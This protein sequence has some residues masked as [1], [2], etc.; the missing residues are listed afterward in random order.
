M[1][2]RKDMTKLLALLAL[3]AA[4]PAA[5][6][7]SSD[8]VRLFESACLDGQAQLPAGEALKVGFN[9]LPAV[10]QQRLNS[11]ASANVWRISGDRQA[12]LYLLEYSASGDAAR[13]IC[14]VASEGIDLQSASAAVERRVAGSVLPR[15]ADESS[16][17]IQLND[18]YLA[19]ATHVGDLKVLQIN[20]LSPQEL[21]AADAHL[22]AVPR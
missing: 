20:W 3:A 10:L 21:R 22:S 14:G 5:A 16:Q 7:S 12:Y 4:S 9:Q 11:P 2:G 19:T 6:A 13:K 18:G 17:W 1:P 15:K 8:V